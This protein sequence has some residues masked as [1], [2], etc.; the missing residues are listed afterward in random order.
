MGRKWTLSSRNTQEYLR[1]MEKQ[2]Q[3]FGLRKLTVGVASVLLGTT[4]VIG[5]STVAHA[6]SNSES[7]SS[8]A[9]AIQSEKTVSLS[10]KQGD[11]AQ[12]SEK[13]KSTAETTTLNSEQTQQ[14]LTQDAVKEQKIQD[15][16]S[17]VKHTEFTADKTDI[18]SGDNITLTSIPMR[19][20][21]G[22]FTKLSFPKPVMALTQPTQ[23]AMELIQ[24]IL[25]N[26][27]VITGTEV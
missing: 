24:L 7:A 12:N 4:I 16:D 2:R 14:P 23:M 21:R 26:S 13:S 8:S 17:Q 6:D 25:V 18:S 11:K 27:K 20:R 1:K 19:L 15:G 10:N 9:V 5:G 22:M 3:R